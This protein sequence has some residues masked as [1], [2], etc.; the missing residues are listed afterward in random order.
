MH[1][2]TVY[3]RGLATQHFL[4]HRFK[5][6]IFR[7]PLEHITGKSALKLPG[8]M[9]IRTAAY[10]IELDGRGI[11]TEIANDMDNAENKPLAAGEHWR[12]PRFRLIR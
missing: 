8:L 1:N 10:N 3:V 7:M 4:W 2:F 9:T 12:R 5:E 6:T 11:I